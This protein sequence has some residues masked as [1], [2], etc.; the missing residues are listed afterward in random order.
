[1]SIYLRV[2]EG[3]TSNVTSLYYTHCMPGSRYVTCKAR[4]G[5]VLQLVSALVSML[6]SSVFV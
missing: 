6:V 4:F 2:L 1:M 3:Q 5:L